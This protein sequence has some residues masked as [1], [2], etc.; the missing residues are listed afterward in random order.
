MPDWLPISKL[1]CTDC[2][3][4]L[5]DP[6]DGTQDSEIS[7]K[8]Y[9]NCDFCDS[10]NVAMS[11]RFSDELAHRLGHEDSDVFLLYT[12]CPVIDCGKRTPNPMCNEHW[13]MVPSKDRQRFWREDDK[14][15]W[16]VRLATRVTTSLL[17]NDGVATGAYVKT[18][19]F[20]MEG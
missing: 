17:D 4:P 5:G 10:M 2:N 12:R 6:R 1:T 20:K 8:F 9:I 14:A 19:T 7:C 18:Y 3:T 11:R 16:L 13:E 15:G